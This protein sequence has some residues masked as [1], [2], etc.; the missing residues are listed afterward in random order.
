MRQQLMI[1]KR[2]LR[3]MEITIF[4][5]PEFGH[6]KG[7]QKVYSCTIPAK[8]Q[9]DAL[10]KTFKTFNVQDTVPEDYEARFIR[11]GDIV[12]IEE[13]KRGVAYYRLHSGGWKKINRIHVR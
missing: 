10:E 6:T 13:E 3:I 1:L 4:Q 7:Y 2:R 11:T 8:D 5:T 9:T 12:S